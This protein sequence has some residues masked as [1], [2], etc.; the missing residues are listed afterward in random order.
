[1]TAPLSRFS[2]IFLLLFGVNNDQVAQ[3]KFSLTGGWGY[4]ELVNIGAQWNFS[5][6]C[7]FSLY[8]GSNFG[9]NNKTLW[10]AGLSFDQTFQKP[11]LWK[12]KAGYSLGTLLW[13]SN[14]DFYYFTNIAFPVMALLA[15]PVSKS[16]SARIEGGPI[17]NM[18]AQSDRKQNV[19]AGFPARFNGNVRVSI[20]Y[21][22]AGK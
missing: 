21:K 19:E 7:S 15:C 22:L 16:V 13:T 11:L 18:V 3:G 20:I 6:A 2:F 10:S 8:G 12:L 5:K 17:V 14:N 1:M 4:Y 9:V